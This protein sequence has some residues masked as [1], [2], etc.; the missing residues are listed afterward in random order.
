M[1]D[2]HAVHALMKNEGG[3]QKLL[4]EVERKLG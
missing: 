1:I 4:F 3:E 2:I